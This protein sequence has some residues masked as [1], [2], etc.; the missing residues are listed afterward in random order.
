MVY[1]P[2]GVGKTFFALGVA[3][4]VASAGE[5]LGWK[6]PRARGVLFLDGE[7]PARVLQERIANTIASHPS[8]PTAPMRIVTPD[9]QPQGMLDLTDANDQDRLAKHL[10]GIDLI[11]ADNISTLC[12]TGRENEAEG[13]LPIQQWALQQRA[14]GRSVLFVHHAGKGG[15]QR[16]TSRREDI[17]DTVIA[18][19]RPPDYTPENGAS[20]EV[21][22]EKSRGFYGEDSKP[23][24]AS[25]TTYL[26]GRQ[27]WATRPLEESTFERVISLHQDGLSPN[28]I[29]TELNIHKSRVSRHLKRARDEGRIKDGG[30]S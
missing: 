8:E 9:R 16:G 30:P 5:F 6:A 11:I 14:A 15:T 3:Y 1:A 7:M 29:S 20:F 22:F 27:I 17:L 24:E 12:R 25:L 13:W 26:D 18:L 10:D 2:R 4:A 28:E 21:H 23:F 19:K